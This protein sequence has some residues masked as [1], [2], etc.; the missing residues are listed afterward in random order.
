MEERSE[1]RSI[2]F[3][4]FCFL[5]FVG[6]RPNVS[7]IFWHDLPL[8]LRWKDRRTID[9]TMGTLPREWRILLRSH[10]LEVW[11]WSMRVQCVRVCKVL[12]FL[13]TKHTHHRPLRSSSEHVIVWTIPLTWFESPLIIRPFTKFFFLPRGPTAAQSVRQQPPEQ[14]SIFYPNILRIYF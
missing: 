1:T 2:F 10:K 4:S 5:I 14:L 8:R 3:E 11:R 9:Q 7:R 6:L 13:P 12:V